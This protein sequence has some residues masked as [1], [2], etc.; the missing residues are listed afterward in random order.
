[1]RCNGDCFNCVFADC[2]ANK[3]EI[4]ELMRLEQEGKEKKL[5]NTTGA[6]GKKLIDAQLAKI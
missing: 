3:K 2:I 5:Y 1:M 6:G 4:A